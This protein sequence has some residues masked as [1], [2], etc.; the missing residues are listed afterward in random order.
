MSG[1]T[2]QLGGP[3]DAQVE[4]LVHDLRAA[5]SLPKGI[6]VGFVAMIVG[7]AIWAGITVATNYQI[8]WMSVGVGLLVGFAVR[9][10]GG[11][12]DNAFGLAGAALALIGCV[13]GNLLCGCY[14]V[15][16][17]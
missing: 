6:A 12:I 14:F 17:E 16:V 8:G 10:G 3:T 5:S 9:V 13:L 4:Q 1:G 15:T 11:G 7:A 2:A